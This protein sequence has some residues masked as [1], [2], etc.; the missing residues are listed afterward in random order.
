MGQFS[1]TKYPTAMK[2]LNQIPQKEEFLAK[3]AAQQIQT[4]MEKKYPR[5]AASTKTKMIIECLIEL[6]EERKFIAAHR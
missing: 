2:N 1:E 6:T 3:K 4:W 5:L